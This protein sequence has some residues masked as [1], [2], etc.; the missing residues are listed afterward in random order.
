[1]AFVYPL[2]GREISEVPKWYSTVAL[3]YTPVLDGEAGLSVQ[4]TT[5]LNDQRVSDL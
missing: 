2:L 4:D 1:M 3:S 5:T